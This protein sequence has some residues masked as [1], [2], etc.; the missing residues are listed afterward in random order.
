MSVEQERRQEWRPERGEAPFDLGEVFYS[1][2][3]E[4]GIIQSGNYVFQRVAHYEWDELIGAP[5]KTVRHPEM[6]KAVFRVFWDELKAGKVTAAYVNNRAKDG[7]HYWVFAI[8]A[9]CKGGYLSARIKPTSELLEPV[10]ALYHKLH[11]AEEQGSSVD[12]STA[13]L[14]EGLRAM[15]FADYDSFVLKALGTE[16]VSECRELGIPPTANVTGATELVDLAKQ[17]V[18]ATRE[19]SGEFSY[20]EGIPR[21]LQIK[22]ARVE[23]TD[24][25]LS[26]LARNYEGMSIDMSDWFEAHVVGENTSFS[27][28]RG[29]IERAMLVGSVAT[30]LARCDKQ[31]LAERRGLGGVDIMPERAMLSELQASYKAKSREAFAQVASEAGRIVAS[32]RDMKR[33]LLG[34][35]TLR[36][37][38]KIED[39]RSGEANAGIGDI[40]AQLAAAQERANTHRNTILERSERM[41]ELAAE[42]Q[43]PERSHL[44]DLLLYGPR[45][46]PAVE[47]SPA[48]KKSAA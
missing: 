19:L 30:I 15:G 1:R 7:L 41:A 26:V 42:M 29:T 11:K 46:L 21:N 28:I 32:C 6:P 3:D 37:A 23:R 39:S 48:P 43:G 33:M 45:M 35:D 40:I 47:K 25:P 8:V 27:S 38:F 5:H 4:R 20:L 10:K 13:A 16:L 18:E 9:P 34:L 36:V 24:G 17:I 12:D 14:L 22:A 31:L 2:T 44:P